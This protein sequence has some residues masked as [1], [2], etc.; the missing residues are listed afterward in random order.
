MIFGKITG[1]VVRKSKY[2]L[3]NNKSEICLIGGGLLIVAGNVVN[4]YQSTKLNEVLERHR[5][6]CAL[7]HEDAEEGIITEKEE[8]ASITHQYIRTGW[9]FVKLY[10]PGV[11]LNVAGFVLVG[12]SHKIMKD[13]NRALI[14]AYGAMS[15]AYQ[16]YRQRVIDTYGVDIDRNIKY[17]LVQKEGEEVVIDE[18]G[19]EIVEKKLQDCFDPDMPMSAPY[20]YVIE[21]SPS[22]FEEGQPSAL[23]L[24]ND[25]LALQADFNDIL[26]HDGY[27]FLNDI[28]R[29]LEDPR[30]PNSPHPCEAGQIVGWRTKENGSKG[31]GYIDFGIFTAKNKEFING[32]RSFCVLEFN[33]EG[34][35]IGDDVD[36]FRKVG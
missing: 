32:N 24:K 15:A 13:R 23:Y 8:K 3:L 28:L 11:L 34:N 31:D 14:A 20:T 18:Q 22:R 16:N 25:L 12:K 27:V 10:A 9:S 36:C 19:R 5:E 1:K 21:M 4:C 17:G 33:C 26:Q 6:G 35:I 30:D 2:F 29:K 7:V